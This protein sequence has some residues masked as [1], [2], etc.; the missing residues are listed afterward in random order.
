MQLHKRFTGEQ[1]NNIFSHYMTGIMSVNECLEYLGISR[2]RFFKLAQ[3]Y[4][5]KGE[6]DL[7]YQ[8]QSP[9]RLGEQAEQLII[10]ELQNDQQLIADPCIPIYIYNYSA[11][12]DNLS[13]QGVEV[14]LPTI[15]NRA[16]EHNYYQPH[17]KKIEHSREVV[18]HSIGEMLQ[19]D[20]SLHLWSPDAH[21]K[22]SLITTLDDYSRKMLYA[23]FF[24]RESTAAH[25]LA[26]KTVISRYGL[27]S[28]YYTDQLRTFRFVTKGESVWSEQH[29]QTD[30]VNP[31]WKRAMQEAGV[32]VIYALSP[33]AKGKIER[34]YRWLQDRVVRKCV[35]HHVTTVR[36]AN[37][38]LKEEVHQYNYK[39]VHSTTLEIPQLRFQ[40]AKRENNSFFTPLAISPEKIIDDIF[41]LRFTRQVDSYHNISLQTHKFKLSVPCFE[42]VVIN[43][44]PNFQNQ[45][46][47]MRIWS[48]RQLILAKT[49][50]RTDFPRVYF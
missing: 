47:N 46:I 12:K 3:E 25:L 24:E 28:Q 37:E 27:P 39:R 17:Q 1:I 15:I 4:R 6:L 9:T 44:I 21:Q 26:G 11:I 22:W 31:Q 41:C 33:Q 34:P 32:K 8:R 5:Q 35:R 48:N 20:S 10:K 50:P 29:L 2:S 13:E 49:F 40:K 36:E 14:S 16:K 30:D 45:T 7:S 19:H 42:E 23:L 43:L 18:T 38:I